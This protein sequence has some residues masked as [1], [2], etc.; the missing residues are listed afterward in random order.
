MKVNLKVDRGSKINIPLS[1][2]SYMI[3]DRRKVSLSVWLQNSFSFE[4]PFY[5]FHVTTA[6]V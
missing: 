2:H 6:S 4:F 5:I 1:R 3:Y